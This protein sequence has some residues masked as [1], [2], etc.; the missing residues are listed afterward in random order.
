MRRIVTGHNESGKS[1]IAIDGPPARSIGEDV[2]GLFEIWNT[3]G[4]LIDT[5]D[6]QDRADSEIILSPPA[7]GTKFRYFQI[8]PTPEGVP[9][10]VL[11]DLA[12]QA[13]DRIGAAHHRIDTSK[14]PAMHKTD[15][16]DYIILLK[17]DVSLLL[18]EEEVR[19]EPFDT[20]VQRGTN[21]AWV[22][23]GDE[24]ALLIAVLIDSELKD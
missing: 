18:D 5:T 17:G 3:D 12:A 11:Q 15:T 23:H 21:H 10:D 22:N 6:N 19:L 2:G 7:N 1:V 20:V 16:I 8:N 4:T 24:P 14:H 13:F 9:W